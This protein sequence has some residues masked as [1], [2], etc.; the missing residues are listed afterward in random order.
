MS[1]IP[2]D[3][4][5]DELRQFVE[6]ILRLKEEADGIASDIKDVYAEAKGRGYDKTALGDLV[7]HLRKD[8]AKIA[9]REALFDLYLERYQ[10][11]PRTHAGARVDRAAPS[12]NPLAAE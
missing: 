7:T 12:V 5:A 10:N 6:R 4:A 9:E 8:P 2:D 11:A 3:I 1:A